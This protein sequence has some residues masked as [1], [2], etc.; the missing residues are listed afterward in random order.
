MKIPV[1]LPMCLIVELWRSAV[2]LFVGMESP[3]FKPI[4]VRYSLPAPEASMVG[5]FTQGLVS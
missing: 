4:S 3:R 5:K 2:T 1:P